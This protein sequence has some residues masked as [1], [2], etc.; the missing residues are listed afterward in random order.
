MDAGAFLFGKPALGADQD[1]RRKAMLRERC[2]SILPAFLA[3]EG[4]QRGQA[5]SL[6]FLDEM[7][8]EA[9]I[10]IHSLE[11]PPEDMYLLVEEELTDYRLAT[12]M[13]P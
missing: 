7:G 9:M 5:E 2:R 10:L 4:I 6:R 8:I 1:R 3:V 11:T 13:I 12:A